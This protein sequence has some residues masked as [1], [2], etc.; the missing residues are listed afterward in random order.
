[1]RKKL[2]KN[3]AL[4]VSST[5]LAYVLKD[6]LKNAYFYL[7]DSAGSLSAYLIENFQKS[8][9][10]QITSEPWY[11]S[12]VIQYIGDNVFNHYMEKLHYVNAKLGSDIITYFL[13]VFGLSALAGLIGYIASR[14][15]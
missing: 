10:Q 3:A 12:S 1:M 2:L 9:Y 6:Y 14:I 13:L 8:L 5:G 15:D 4:L 11:N 7:K